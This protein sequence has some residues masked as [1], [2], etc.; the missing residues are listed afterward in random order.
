MTTTPAPE[1]S[2][3]ELEAHI[4]DLSLLMIAAYARYERSYSR[5]ERDEARRMLG[6]LNQAILSRPEAVQAARH[7]A[8]E[9]RLDEGVDY[10]AVM[11]ARHGTEMPK[12]GIAR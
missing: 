11:G 8:F 6:L 5:A 4:D 1:M 12:G 2:D 9:H 10:F 3:R 7:A